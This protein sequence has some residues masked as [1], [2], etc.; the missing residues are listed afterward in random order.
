[1]AFAGLAPPEPF[2]PTPGLPSVPWPQ[3]HGMFN[4]YLLATG[5]AEFLPE[6]RKALL[7]HCLGAEGQRIFNTLPDTNPPSTAQDTG[8][9]A[10]SKPDVYAIGVTSL[11]QHFATTSNLVIERH[12]FHRRFQSPGQ[13]VHDFVAALRELATPCCF[14]SLEALRDQFVTGVSSNRVRERLL[15]EGSSL[16]FSTAVQI[17]LQ[18]GQ[19]AEQMKEFSASVQPVSA[20]PSKYSEP[21]SQ[22]S[23]SQHVTRSHQQHIP[24]S[25]TTSRAAQG[26]RPSS[27]D[28]SDRR[29]SPSAPRAQSPHCFRCGSRGHRASW[30][31]CPAQGQRCLLC[32][33]IGHFKKV[34]NQKRSQSTVREVVV[35]N[36]SEDDAVQVLV[37]SASYN[38][39]N[40]Y[41]CSNRAV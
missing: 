2:L 30:T 14:A 19:A 21:P 16:P 3:W 23:R 22:S 24:R 6:R 38:L 18:Q 39:R 41:R 20:R 33:R 36:S 12:R 4:V 7:L 8:K 10:T 35:D 15:L 29:R 28:R 34:C 5:A 31:R 17:A 32:G 13:S 40:S 37:A 9:D 26:N 11:A 1:M 27:R 25:A